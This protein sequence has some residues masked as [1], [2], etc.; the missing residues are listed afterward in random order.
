MGVNHL[1]TIFTVQCSHPWAKK[2]WV[3]NSPLLSVISFFL[4]FP[5]NLNLIF[6]NEPKKTKLKSIS[7]SSTVIENLVTLGVR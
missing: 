1:V 7:V 2:S 4:G 6:L 5:P 3:L